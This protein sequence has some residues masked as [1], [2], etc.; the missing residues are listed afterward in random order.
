MNSEKVC[1]IFER[2]HWKLE[3]REGK[4][5]KGSLECEAETDNR[6]RMQCKLWLLFGHLS[7]LEEI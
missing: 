5:E 1:I 4:S 3:G 6:G 7:S 2:R